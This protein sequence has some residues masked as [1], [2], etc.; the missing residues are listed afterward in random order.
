MSCRT[1]WTLVNLALFELLN[2]DRSRAHPNGVMLAVLKSWQ[3][4]THDIP[5][6]ENLHVDSMYS[7]GSFQLSSV[8]Q[9]QLSASAKHSVT[10]IRLWHNTGRS[11]PLCVYLRDACVRARKQYVPQTIVPS[12]SSLW[13]FRGWVQ[14]EDSSPRDPQ[15]LSQTAL[16]FACLVD[17]RTLIGTL[18][19]I[20]STMRT[21][22]FS[23]PRTHLAFGDRHRWPGP[24]PARPPPV[25]FSSNFTIAISAWLVSQKNACQTHS[26]SIN[27]W[28]NKPQWE[29][30]KKKCRLIFLG[31]SFATFKLCCVRHWISLSLTTRAEKKAFREFSKILAVQ[32]MY[33]LPPSFPTRLKWTHETVDCWKF[34]GEH[35]LL[36]SNNKTFL[37]T[38]TSKYIFSK[39]EV[40]WCVLKG[41]VYCVRLN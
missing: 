30:A 23:A 22:M 9:R 37:W 24:R 11:T 18:R 32:T 17:S 36:Q 8:P 33:Q 12:V 15:W 19:H 20:A 29:K 27:L 35:A 14:E 25:Q 6:G 1:S 26:L 28:E 4:C 13:R 38:E 21:A 7:G 3:E 10:R 16:F 31:G 2:L 34:S 5:D 41:C 39:C 40:R